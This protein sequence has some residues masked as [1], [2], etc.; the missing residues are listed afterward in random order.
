MR[1]AILEDDPSHLEVVSHWLR[2]AGHQ[3]HA[4][5]RGRELMRVLKHETFD[6]L[7]LDWNLPELSGIEVL[8]EV[9]ERL[10]SRIPAIFATARDQE[11][12]AVIALSAGADDYLVK[13]IRRMELLARLDAV[14]R[15]FGRVEVFEVGEFRVDS[16]VRGIWCDGRWLELRGKD[17]DLASLLLHNVGRLLSRGHLRETIWGQNAGPVS[18]SLDT[19]VSR[20]RRR[21][22]LTPE[23]GWR[24]HSVYG[25]GYRL[26][27]LTGSRLRTAGS[28]V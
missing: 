27:R 13:P 15:R 22:G 10:R 9:R 19:H 3:I 18:R 2:G 14:T 6:A 25:R 26:D 28:D 4:F 11:R 5:T 7:L 23:N 17:F 8:R 21:L 16:Q 24:L 20:I 12:D 1:I